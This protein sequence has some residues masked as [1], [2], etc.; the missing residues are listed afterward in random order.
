MV[1]CSI[2]SCQ[3]RPGKFVGRKIKYF[4]FPTDPEYFKKWIEICPGV[5]HDNLKTHGQCFLAKCKIYNFGF[6]SKWSFHILLALG[7]LRTSWLFVYGLK[8]LGNLSFAIPNSNLQSSKG[9][10]SELKSEF[11]VIVM[12]A[13]TGHQALACTGFPIWG[14]PTDLDIRGCQ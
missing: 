14:C 5:K 12:S 4:R 10:N 7:N 6:L 9:V 2:K 11:W 1:N 8:I 3:N 13:H